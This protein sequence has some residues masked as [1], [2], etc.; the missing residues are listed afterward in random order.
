MAKKV[1]EKKMV[2]RYS[3]SVDWDFD[4]LSISQV[5]ILLDAKERYLLETFPGAEI[6]LSLE[7]SDWDRG[8][9]LKIIAE[10]LETDEEYNK[11]VVLMAAQEAARLERDR[12][13]FERLSR[14]FG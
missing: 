7:S 12:K 11:R 8:D 6:R 10:T 14:K 1:P 9:K 13:E 2:K 4:G 3:D 5:H